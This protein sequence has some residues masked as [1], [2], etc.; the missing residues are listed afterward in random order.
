[1]VAAIAAAV[2]IPGVS[3]CGSGYTTGTLNA[4]APADGATFIDQVGKKCSAASNGEYNIVTHALP[5]AAD[6]QRL[7]LARRLSGNDHSLDLMGMDVV[8][9]A[10]FADAGWIEPVPQDLV[11]TIQSDSLPGPYETAVWKTKDD[12]E[13]RLYA[14]PT[15]TNTQLLWFRPDILQKYLGKTTPPKTWDEVLSNTEQIRA[16][17]GPSYV[18]VQGK[19]YE[20]LMVWFNSLLTSA[21]GQVVDPDDP[22]KITLNDTPAHRA[23]TEKALEIMRAVAR[24]PGHDPS[25]SNSDE[26]SGRLGME[27]GLAAFEINYPFVFP[28]MRSNAAAGDVAFFPEMAQRYGKLFADADNPPADSE[29]GPVNQFV[30]TKFDF[31]RYPAVN[32]GTPAKVTVGGVNLAVASTS[33]QKSLAFK[34]AQCLTNSDAQKVYSISGGTPPTIAS[35]YDDPEFKQTYPMG[36]DIKAQ[37]ESDASS[38][39]PASPVYQAI[40]TLLVAKLS[41]PGGLDPKSGVDVLAEQVRKAIDGE[42]LI[43]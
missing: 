43:P 1:M 19:Q 30:R 17:G 18:M 16:K 32:A 34:A 21:G 35:L 37:L 28:S 2:V 33:K 27:N 29:L 6:D 3:A 26:G 11:N 25:I 7:Q 13:K 40:S 20:G 23:A 22:S 8:W 42:G 31:T 12:S 41:P 15:W 36:D 24:A 38:T 9:T 14:I 10:E 39:R 4:Y 5:K